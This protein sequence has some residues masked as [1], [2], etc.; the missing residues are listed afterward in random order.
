MSH[1]TVTITLRLPPS[2]ADQLEAEARRRGTS[3][4]ALA[5]EAIEVGLQPAPSLEPRSTREGGG[6]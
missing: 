6:S 1:P 5:V 3:K 4:N 2:L